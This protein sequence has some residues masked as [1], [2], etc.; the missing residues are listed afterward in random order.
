MASTEAS[1]PE[2]KSSIDPEL[3]D[4]V[5]ALLEGDGPIATRAADEGGPKLIQFHSSRN[6]T[7]GLNSQGIRISFP[8]NEDWSI[9]SWYSADRATE[10]SVL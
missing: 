9:W 10:D 8:R 1:E 4:D 2:G 3:H 6:V 7:I 5:A